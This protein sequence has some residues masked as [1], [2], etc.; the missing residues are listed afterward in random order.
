MVD[1]VRIY[2]RALSADEVSELASPPGPVGHWEFDD[3]EGTIAVD[4]SGNGLDGILMGDPQWSA[5]IIGGALDF[6]GDGDY[7]DCGND[8]SLDITGPISIAL[9]IRPDADDPEGQATTTAPMAKAMAGMSPSWSYQVRY[10]WGSP[11]PYMAFTFN[12]SPRAWVY[13]GKNLERYEWCH[14][15]CSHDGTTLKCYLNGE[16]TDSTPMGAITSS[17][18]PVLIGSDGWACDWIGAIDEVAIYDRALSADEILEL[19]G[20]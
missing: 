3:G 10:G 9:W 15:A 7:V 2:D 18:T 12:S 6:D 8:A 14:I 1:E 16:E 17:E 5:G 19:A 4:S 13:V 11:Q 20:Q